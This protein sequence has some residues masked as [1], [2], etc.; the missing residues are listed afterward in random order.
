MYLTE[1]STLARSMVNVHWS[2]VFATGD[3]VKSLSRSMARRGALTTAA[4]HWPVT[5]PTVQ[6]SSGVMVTVTSSPSLAVVAFSVSP[7]LRLMVPCSFVPTVR[8]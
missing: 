4:C 1:I 7:T 6:P 8:L 2:S 3:S 5:V